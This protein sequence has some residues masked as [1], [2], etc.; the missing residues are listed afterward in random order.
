ML[1]TWN[2]FWR[3]LGLI[4]CLCT[5]GQA[6]A[7]QNK[8][9]IDLLGVGSPT[10]GRSP[11]APG[12]SG[13]PGSG[14]SVR[15]TD[16]EDCSGATP[17]ELRN[18]LQLGGRKTALIVRG[19][20]YG[21]NVQAL[22]FIR[23]IADASAVDPSVQ[24]FLKENLSQPYIDDQA[25]VKA[26]F[27][28]AGYNVK[29]IT[30]ADFA[31][32]LSDMKA[33]VL[34]V[35]KKPETS[36]FVF[37][38]HGNT[39][40]I[41]LTDER[42][43]N[44]PGLEELLRKR[45]DHHPQQ[46][47]SVDE[48]LDLRKGHKL[49][50]LILHGCQNATDVYAKE[51]KGA[52]LQNTFA[53]CVSPDGQGFFAGWVTFSVYLRPETPTVLNRF[54]CH[55]SKRGKLTPAQLRVSSRH[56]MR[57]DG[58]G[59]TCSRLAFEGDGSG[60]EKK[61]LDADREVRPHSMEYLAQVEPICN[62][63]KLLEA[64]KFENT[65]LAED[66][67]TY[68]VRQVRYC[69]ANKI[70]MQQAGKGT[71]PAIS[72]PPTTSEVNALL[73]YHAFP[74]LD[75]V[76]RAVAPGLVALKEPAIRIKESDPESLFLDLALQVRKGKELEEIL[77]I[78]RSVCEGDLKDGIKNADGFGIGPQLAERIES[79]LNAV[80]KALDETVVDLSIQLSFRKFR[81][82]DSSTN[83]L[84]P[85][86]HGY[87]LAI[88]DVP[89]KLKESRKTPYEI[90]I[91]MKT[92]NRLADRILTELFDS[93]FYVGKFVVH[94]YARMNS[95]D[96]LTKGYGNAALL[97]SSWSIRGY[98]GLLGDDDGWRYGS[99]KMSIHLSVFPAGDLKLRLV[100][101]VYVQLGSEWP[102]SGTLSSIL[103][104]KAGAEVRARVS[105]VDFADYIPKEVKSEIVGVVK[106]Q[107][108]DISTQAASVYIDRVN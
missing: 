102:F 64:V 47:L 79:T 38:G 104:D 53:D 69:T 72:N 59:Y 94:C 70:S 10:D 61:E 50:G 87:N 19:G 71:P 15:T 23:R 75:E 63:L 101:R 100:P 52:K 80:T 25:A 33:A 4:L 26:V 8:P 2:G 34:D 60:I 48:L 31:G 40:Q 85:T 99:L 3:A 37:Y 97:R 16:P 108:V 20:K 42:E 54:F 46:T 5:A 11:G 66:I 28:R 17:E 83:R 81:P 14:Q 56:F 74:I 105:S 1:S 27:E 24:K 35:L 92:L 91:S 18:Q 44:V 93:W 78:V 68:L 106:I 90:H 95:F 29:T 32:R 107:A 41:W 36:V 77:K 39:S 89:A 88:G 9:R 62:V 58:I 65:N 103:T 51:R 82:K 7:V 84:K 57:S 98:W 43:N 49:D 45:E 30:S 12:A 76:V 86:V 73:A 13:R 55:M 21:I 6:V 22:E 96:S 67:K